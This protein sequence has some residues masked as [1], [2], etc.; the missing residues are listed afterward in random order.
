MPEPPDILAGGWIMA[1]D[2]LSAMDRFENPSDKMSCIL[3]ACRVIS[4]LL[5]LANDVRGGGRESGV[6][7]DE[8]LPVSIF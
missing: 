1:A 6:G 8:F 3:N 4:T 7:A 5:A 2:A